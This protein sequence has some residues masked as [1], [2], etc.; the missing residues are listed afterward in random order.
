MAKKQTSAKF[1]FKI[2]YEASLLTLIT[3]LISIA[4]LSWQIINYF[5][6]AQVRLITPDQITIGSS[7]RM[8]YP[9]RGGGPYVHFITRMSYVNAAS[10]GYN[11]TVSVERVSI[12]VDGQHTFEYRWYYFVT[13]DAVGKDGTELDVK[14][15]LYAQPFAL[16]AGS[17]ASHE[18]LFQPWQKD[19]SSAAS[20]CTAS[21]NYVDW[22]TFVQWFGN[23]HVLEFEFLA[24]IF[25]REKPV[26]GKCKVEMSPE[27]FAELLTREWASPVCTPIK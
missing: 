26:S 16:A 22:K 4:S 6:G 15:T 8:N 21:D 13:S 11:A 27:R 23:K 10:A 17:S 12:T 19:C 20:P 7:P 5:E 1:R 2:S 3:F 24:D 14:K 9:N 25:G 18:T